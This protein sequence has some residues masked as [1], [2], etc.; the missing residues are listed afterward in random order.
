MT[1]SSV[2][3]AAQQ[4]TPR[5]T[6]A[7]IMGGV[8]S[9]H[10]VSL[11]SGGGIADAAE[12]LGHQVIRLVI[13]RDGSWTTNG[14]PGLDAALAALRASDVAV[15]AMHGEGGEDGT[16]QGF[17]ELLGVKYV[18][19]GVAASAISLDKHATKAVLATH[20]IPVAPG[21]ALRGEALAQAGSDPQDA[22]VQLKEAGVAYPVFVK[23][24]SGGSSFGVTRVSETAELAPAIAEAAALD[25]Q[26]LIEQEMIGREIDLSVIEL[27]DGSLEVGPAL[28]IHSDPS[29]PFFNAEA[30]YSSAAT[31]F[32]I[33]A[34]IDPE[35][36]ERLRSTAIAVFK[37]LGC[38]GLAR[39]D[40]FVLENGEPVVNELNT[41]PGFTPA[42]Q[43]PRMWAATG[44]SYAD[45]VN[46]LLA[47][48]VADRA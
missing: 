35:L 29:Q 7:V 46:V 27:P 2:T 45:V 32:V 3:A 15:P 36:A 13:G 18:G 40:F 31:E 28:E 17:L 12:S 23:P 1:T 11:A 16:I 19:S 39:V 34:Q 26:V 38:R 24:A 47:T 4:R 37:S 8:S 22:A 41:F 10:D 30:K 44:L 33:P 43:Y 9:E 5:M 6:V 25:T 21:I 42:S 14:T 48:A 20:G